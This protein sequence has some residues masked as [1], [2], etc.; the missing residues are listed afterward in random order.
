MDATTHVRLGGEYLLLWPVKQL[1]APLRLGLFYDPEP[2]EGH[3]Q[4]V[5]GIALGSGISTSR[6]SIDLAY[7]LRWADDIDTGNII[8]TS[9]ADMTRHTVLA[10]LIYYF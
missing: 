10:S 5:F 4:D 8:A 1:A 3:P 2:S 9:S 7:Q 6:F